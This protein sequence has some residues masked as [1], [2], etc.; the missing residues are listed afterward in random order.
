MQKSVQK[1]ILTL[2]LLGASTTFAATSVK[3]GNGQSVS[4]AAPTKR[5]VS[6]SPHATELLFSAGAGANVV[7]VTQE[8]DYPIAAQKIPKVGTYNQISLEAILRLKPDLVVTWQDAA[9][10]KEINRLKQL[11]IPV[12]VSHPLKLEDIPKE[13][14][15]L[16][17]LNQTENTAQKNTQSFT[18]N[19]KTLRSQYQN[20]KKVQTLV[21]V[22]ESPLYTVSNQSFLGQL[23]ILCG[24]ENVFAK[25][26]TP[27]AQVGKEAVM[28]TQ[29]QVIIT[30]LPK[31]DAN[32]WQTMRLPASQNNRIYTISN[33]NRP[34]L[35]L[36]SAANQ[37]CRHIDQ[38][39]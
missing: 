20:K 1:L 5:I 14:I 7:G 16:G 24:G 12:F 30:T 36:I 11:G 31:Y 37:I 2:T 3:D 9:Q 25:I 4:V 6:L 38:A 32:L 22:S 18:N 21:A 10:A 17:K 27:A 33:S 34:T 39:R 26:K 35:R 13:I 19:V 8:S 29:A 28:R 15:A 23:I